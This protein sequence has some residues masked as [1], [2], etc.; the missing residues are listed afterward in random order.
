MIERRIGPC[1][2]RRGGEAALMLGESV[3]V[4]RI[5][6]GQV[7]HMNE[8]L[9]AGDPRSKLGC[10]FARFALAII[11][12]AGRGK[13]CLRQLGP[14]RPVAS[15]NARSEPHAVAAWRRAEYSCCTLKTGERIVLGALF[16]RGDGAD[17]RGKERDLAW[18]DVAEQAGNAQRHIDPRPAQHRQRQHLKAVDASSTRR[19]RSAGSRSA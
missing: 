5:L 8:G 18:K 17:G 3:G 15:R 14:I 1:F 11:S 6:S 2:R 13:I 19:P 16:E 9:G 12:M 4:E 7:L 10:R